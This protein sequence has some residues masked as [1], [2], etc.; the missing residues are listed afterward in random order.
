MIQILK[1]QLPF[2]TINLSTGILHFMLSNITNNHHKKQITC[3][4]TNSVLMS[5]IGQKLYILP[6]VIE[7]SQLSSGTKLHIRGSCFKHITTFNY[8]QQY[9]IQ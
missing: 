2:N 3:K 1:M 7:M 4:L 6:D 9:L 5:G 8:F